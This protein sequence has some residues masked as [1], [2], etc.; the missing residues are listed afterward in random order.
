MGSIS[1]KMEL[2]SR[3]FAFLLPKVEVEHN[4]A[5][6]QYLALNNTETFTEAYTLINI[7]MSS[8][9]KFQKGKN[10]FLQFQV[11]NLFDVAYQSNLS[12]LKY[13]EYYDQS[14]KGHS[15]VYNMG[16]NICLKVSTNF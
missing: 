8:E 7:S 3:L 16:R 10:L 12:R 5:Q 2:K 6:S 13:F 1:Q 9:I 4:S 11:N 15:G 14:A